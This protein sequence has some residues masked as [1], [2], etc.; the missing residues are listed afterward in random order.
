MLKSQNLNSQT[1]LN[2]KRNYAEVHWNYF[3]LLEEDLR[4][5]LNYIEPCIDNLQAYGPMLAKLLL[6]TGSE[7]DATFKDLIKVKGTNCQSSSNK[8]STI[9]DYR[10]FAQQYLQQEFD[11]VEIGFSRSQLSSRPWSDWWETVEGERQPKEE[12]SSLTWWKAYTDVKHHRLE[13]YNK[14]TLGN[15]LEAMAALFILIG[16]LARA[17]KNYDGYRIPVILEYCDRRFGNIQT[18]RI[19]GSAL[20]SNQ[21]PNFCFYPLQKSETP[22]K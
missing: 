17:E 2:N 4:D 6:A 19:E 16:S 8:N 5:I 20:I 12:T 13:R 9:N 10:R 15:T 21:A 3:L 18:I 11:Q 22:T 1:P 14:A 7:I